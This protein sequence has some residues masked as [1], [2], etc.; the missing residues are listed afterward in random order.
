MS[1]FIINGQKVNVALKKTNL[2]SGSMMR[3]AMANVFVSQQSKEIV[4]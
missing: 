1:N 2:D 4:N 3:I